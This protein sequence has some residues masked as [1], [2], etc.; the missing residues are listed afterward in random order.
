MTSERVHLRHL[1]ASDADDFV[2]VRRASRDHL[3]PWEPIPPSGLD[4]YSYDAFDR[5]LA[6]SDTEREQRFAVCLKETDAL[7]GRV[8]LG[9]I[10]RGPFMN[11]RFG[12]WMSTA[13]AG[14]GL[15]T[16]ALGLAVEHAFAPMGEGGLGLHRVCANVVPGNM[17]SRRVLEKLGFVREGYSEKYLQIAGE[18]ADHERWALVNDR[19]GS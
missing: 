3:E 19:R 6:S 11:G 16:E 2:R 1:R 12:Y 18:W 15:M 8:T 13:H 4:L 17:G 14:R 10:E 9:C 5:E 7:I